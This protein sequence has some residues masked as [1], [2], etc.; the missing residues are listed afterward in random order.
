M[1]WKVTD[2]F[3]KRWISTVNNETDKNSTDLDA[4]GRVLQEAIKKERPVGLVS[5]EDLVGLEGQIDVDYFQVKLNFTL[6]EI[7][8][9]TTEDSVFIEVKR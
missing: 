1:D 7:V 9:R 4:I 2:I 8:S 5:S 6:P 3:I